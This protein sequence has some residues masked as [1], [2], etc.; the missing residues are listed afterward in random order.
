MRSELSKTESKGTLMDETPKIDV[1]TQTR[2]DASGGKAEEARAPINER[3]IQVQNFN[4]Y[5]GMNQA[6]F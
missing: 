6:L 5:Y 4:F 2:K 3:Y 1:R